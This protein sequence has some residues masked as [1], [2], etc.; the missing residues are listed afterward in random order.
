MDRH[1]DSTER[2]ATYTYCNLYVC[3]LRNTQASLLVTTVKGQKEFYSDLD[4]RRAK[5]ARK[6]QEVLGYP[7]TKA[8]LRMIDNNMIKN[9]AVTRRDVKISNDIYG[10][11]ANIV[12]GK[13]VRQQP[14]HVREDILPVPPDILERYGDITLA[15]DVYHINGIRF[16]RSISRHLM[17]R[18]TQ[19]IADAK[20]GTLF[21]QVKRVPQRVQGG[22]DLR[23]QRIQL[24]QRQ[25]YGGST[26]DFSLGC[27]R[28]SRTIHR[29]GQPSE[30]RTMPMYLQRT[31]FQ[32]NATQNDYGVASSGRLLA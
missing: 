29:K 21:K 3:D 25:T 7:S 8:F 27:A 13:S 9:C 11:N 26:R 16:F 1:D 5:A 14:P 17:F 6:L 15:I 10:V 4:V 30:Q 2:I 19:A 28:S 23:R 18:T 31:S 20:A 12:K 22:A 32:Q 24:Y